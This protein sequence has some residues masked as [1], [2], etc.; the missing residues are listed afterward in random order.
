VKNL[1]AGK[2]QSHKPAAGPGMMMGMVPMA[3]MPM[4]MAGIPMSMPMMGMNSMNMNM[5]LGV[6]GAM[7][8]GAMG[9]GGVGVPFPQG[10]SRSQARSRP[11][12]VYDLAGEFGQMQVQ[13]LAAAGAGTG[14]GTLSRVPNPGS[15]GY[16]STSL[17]P[18]LG[19][20]SKRMHSF[21]NPKI[22]HEAL[23]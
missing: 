4:A 18:P 19:S 20:G 22:E 8:M 12:T 9:A 13:Q 11:T 1:K 10:T 23:E 3:A 7:G 15:Y 6:P 14:K 21:P 2:S 16:S 5:S 17:R